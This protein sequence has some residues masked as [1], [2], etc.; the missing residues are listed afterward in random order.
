M[1]LH[2]PYGSGRSST[3]TVARPLRS[4]TIT[5]S[6]PPVPGDRV[7]RFVCSAMRS[8]GAGR[9]HDRGVASGRLGNLTAAV[10]GWTVARA[11]LV[12]D[13]GPDPAGCA[14]RCRA[15]TNPVRQRP[16]FAVERC[17]TTT[18]AP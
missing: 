16:R 2:R 15:A 7:L 17:S 4:G 1:L 13:A 10:P 14:P 3:V 9:T 18:C 12:A 5:S 6:M 11:A 8:A